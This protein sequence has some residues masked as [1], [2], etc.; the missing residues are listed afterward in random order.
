MGKSG[1][2]VDNYNKGLK[3]HREGAPN[4][5]AQGDLFRGCAQAVREDNKILIHRKTVLQLFVLIPNKM[6]SVYTVWENDL[7]SMI[8]CQNAES[9]LLS[10][11]TLPVLPRAVLC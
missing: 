6:M 11:L 5:E 3:K 8:P 4:F 2:E 9:G 10:L 7:S 1:M